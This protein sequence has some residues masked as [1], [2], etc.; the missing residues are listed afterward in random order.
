M[1][2]LNLEEKELI[3][4][5]EK[6]QKM[7]P[8]DLADYI[9]EL[10]NDE[11]LV[12][13][14][15]LNKDLLAETFSNLSRKNKNELI[16]KF[17]DDQIRD[18]FN[19]LESDEVVDTILEFP[20]NMVNE[21]LAHVSSEKRPIINE[22]L[23]YP[24]ESVGS[25]MSV[26]FVKASI[27]RTKSEIL[28]RVYNT[29]INAK[30]LEI[31]WI[32]NTGLK[33]IGYVYLADLVRHDSEDI[34]SIIRD[35][36]AYVNTNDD[37]EVA[38]K[39]FNRYH[40]E[41]LPV[42]DSEGR[43][44]GSIVT[45]TILDVLRDEFTEDIYNLQGIETTDDSYL[46]TSIFTIARKRF[47]WLLILMF[48]ATITSALIQ[49]YEAILA[50]TVALVAYIPVLMDT[51]GNSGS[52]S[53]ATVIQS[54]ALNEIEFSDFINVVLKE[55]GVGIIIGILMAIMNFARIMLMDGVSVGVALTV[56]ITLFVIVIISKT[57]GGILPLIAV[58]FNQDPTVMAGPLIT[59]VVDTAAL[60]VYFEI[61]SILL[62]L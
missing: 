9:E 30:N 58:K 12:A 21:L 56:S 28:N 10:D 60:L 32:V 14:K 3:Y 34:S 57:I 41:A 26:D 7:N 20:A 24:E 59:T 40:L 35:V 52:Q 8:V 6:I 47:S 62:N 43:L 1:K 15:L 46:D 50:T 61:A 42:V 27:T 48:T 19:Y 22:L 54:L 49:R 33:L 5:Q 51:G 31:I 45:E 37:Q 11:K 44:V 53:T 4:L 17:S 39:I 18:I 55:V 29:N 36:V 38:A 13:I 16:D 2:N 25:I 23:G